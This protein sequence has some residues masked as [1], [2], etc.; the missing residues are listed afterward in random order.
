MLLALPEEVS[1]LIFAY[2]VGLPP[3]HQKNCEKDPVSLASCE[4]V[5][6]RWKGSIKPLWEE[7][8]RAGIAVVRLL[9]IARNDARLFVDAYQLRQG[10]D[11]DRLMFKRA[12]HRRSALEGLGRG[13]LL[14]GDTESNVLAIVQPT[15]EPER[16]L[17]DINASSGRVLHRILPRTLTTPHHL[18]LWWQGQSE[19]VS[20]FSPCGFRVAFMEANT[21]DLWHCF[22][23]STDFVRC[24]V[25][26]IERPPMAYCWSHDSRFLAFYRTLGNDDPTNDRIVLIRVSDGARAECSVPKYSVSC[27]SFSPDSHTLALL[28]AP[29]RDHI[30]ARSWAVRNRLAFLPTKR[31]F[32]IWRNPLLD[33]EPDS[34][35]KCND[36]QSEGDDTTESGT[37]TADGPSPVLLMCHSVALSSCFPLYPDPLNPHLILATDHP[38]VE[39]SKNGDWVGVGVAGE[40]FI[41]I[42]GDQEGTGIAQKTVPK[43]N[44]DMFRFILIDLNTC[45]YV[46]RSSAIPMFLQGTGSGFTSRI[47][48]HDVEVDNDLLRCHIVYKGQSQAIHQVTG[49]SWK[50]FPLKDPATSYRLDDELGGTPNRQCV[51]SSRSQCFWSV[52]RT[53]LYI[54]EHSLYDGVVVSR[55]NTAGEGEVVFDKL[56]HEDPRFATPRQGFG[57]WYPDRAQFK[58]PDVVYRAP[59]S[60]TREAHLQRASAAAGCHVVWRTHKS[61]HELH[62][63]GRDSLCLCQDGHTTLLNLSAP[64]Y[65]ENGVDHISEPIRALCFMGTW[66]V[67][68]PMRN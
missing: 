36:S 40:P 55:W 66:A 64:R 12:F 42:V 21:R 19:T 53:H 48:V 8:Y 6:R 62:E 56:V 13:N 9:K 14:V 63:L 27:L 29:S 65:P 15:N 2:V 35:S 34:T 52:D 59:Y 61:A 43:L 30:Q 47:Y 37:N 51:A 1:L 49:L 32:W 58:E 18:R 54:T 38:P 41:P 16:P 68:C 50:H 31:W 28:G 26:G 23:D 22:I 39:T 4:S 46:A 24:H 17:T 3:L 25:V 57:T 11:V 44:R 7:L 33:G 67:F 20:N 5:C 10:G 60:F 45:T